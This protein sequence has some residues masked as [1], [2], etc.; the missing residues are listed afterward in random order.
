MNTP[1]AFLSSVV[2]TVLANTSPRQ[3]SINLA[4]TASPQSILC[5]CRRPRYQWKD[6]ETHFRMM[7]TPCAF[8]SSVVAT[9]LANTSPRQESINLAHTASPQSILC[10]CRRPRYQSKALKTHFRVI[11]LPCA[12]SLLL[13]AKLVSDCGPFLHP[14]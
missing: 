10:R 2:A 9:V 3:E 4:H 8:L 1:C 7:N 14:V 5:R 6:L 11:L 13:V 12:S